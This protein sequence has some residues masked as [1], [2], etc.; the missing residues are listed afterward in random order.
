MCAIAVLVRAQG[1]GSRVIRDSHQRG[2]VP[3]CKGHA[4]FL[5]FTPFTC[6]IWT[7]VGWGS[8]ERT[9]DL[10]GRGQ[11]NASHPSTPSTPKHP[12]S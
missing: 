2:P 11:T 12:L 8:V 5:H 4:L 3:H 10:E 7:S 1:S 9:G 6:Y